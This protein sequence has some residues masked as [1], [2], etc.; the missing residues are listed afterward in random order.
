MSNEQDAVK[1]GLENGL[2]YVGEH[3]IPGTSQTLPLYEMDGWINSAEGWNML[4]A[5]QRGEVS[6]ADYEAAKAEFYRQ[7]AAA[8]D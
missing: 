4:A 8:N 1:F 3:T 5:V 2:K 6:Q 7:E